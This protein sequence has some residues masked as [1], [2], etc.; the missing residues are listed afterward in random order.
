M[1]R[2]VVVGP[3]GVGCYFG[4]MLARAG[5]RVTMVGRP[6][7]PGAHLEAMARI[8]LRMD[9][10]GFREVVPVRTSTGTESLAEA[11]L[12]LFCV[13]TVDT[14]A[15]CR[16]IAPHVGGG[17][18]VLDLQNGVDNP[19]RMRGAGVDPIPAVVYVAAAVE[20]PGAVKHRGR[21]DLVIGHRE[22]R[23]D[24][25][26]VAAWLARAGVPCRVSGDIERDLWLKLILNSMANAVSALTGST[27]RGIVDFEPAWNTAL[28][29]AR[30]A[31][32]VARGVGFDFDL[33][34][35]IAQGL[36]VCRTVGD[37]TSSTEQDLARGRPTEI[38]ALNGYIARRGAELGISAPVNETL[39]GLVKMRERAAGGASGT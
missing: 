9:A 24:V 25:E 31:V 8:G 27:Y 17:V 2:V 19:E 39:W 35:V 26:T 16:R 7:K 13:K 1:P 36:A 4:G 34:D 23:S 11:D 32:Q 3:G 14:D 10:V 12:V 33:E 28:E 37:A 30:E 22:R 5:A 21:G 29:V 6:G 15:A 18:P 38:D 20:T